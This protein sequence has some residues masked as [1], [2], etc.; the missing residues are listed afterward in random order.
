MPCRCEPDTRWCDDHS[1]HKWSREGG[2]PCAS[3]YLSSSLFF[4]EEG[5]GWDVMKTV[6]SG[7]HGRMACPGVGGV[8]GRQRGSW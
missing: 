6:G 7:W 4:G 3:L 2:W 8:H 1:P 5:Q